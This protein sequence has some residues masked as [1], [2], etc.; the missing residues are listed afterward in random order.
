MRTI[1]DLPDTQIEALKYLEAQRRVSRAELVR[2]AV[3]E[4]VVK[5]VGHAEAFG[6]WKASA[7]KIDGVKQQR[8]MRDEWPDN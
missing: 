4:Y 6:A 3:A 8:A 1:I 5:R 7:K 2:Q